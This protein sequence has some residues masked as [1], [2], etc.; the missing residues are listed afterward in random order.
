MPTLCPGARPDAIAPRSDNPFPSL[1]RAYA[2]CLGGFLTDANRFYLRITADGVVHG[3]IR[4]HQYGATFRGKKRKRR[5]EI[6]IAHMN[7]TATFVPTRSSST[8]DCDPQGAEYCCTFQVM[9]RLHH[10]DRHTLSCHVHVPVAPDVPAVGTWQQVSTSATIGKDSTFLKHLFQW[11]PLSRHQDDAARGL[12]SSLYPLRPGTYEFRGFTT[13]HRRSRPRTG[14]RVRP[15]ASVQDPCLVTLELLPD[16]TLRGTSREVVQPQ[17]CDLR[18]SWEEDRVTYALEYR[19][20][21]AVG[22]FRYSGAIRMKEEGESGKQRMVTRPDATGTS[23]RE[24]LSGKWYNVDRGHA[25]GY[26]GGRGDFE[27]EL[28]RTDFTPLSVRTDR[29]LVSLHPLQEQPPPRDAIF[30]FTSGDYELSGCATDAD[31]YEYAF[32][33]T[34]QLHPGGKLVGESKERIFRQ[35]SVVYGQWGP[36]QM[37]YMQHYVVHEEVGVYMYTADLI[38]DGAAVQGTWVNTEPEAAPASS[39]HGTFALIVVHATRRWSPCSHVHYPARF[40]AGV[41]TTLLTSAR[42]KT[43]PG[44][45]WMHVFAFCDETWFTPSR[46]H[47]VQ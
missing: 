38:H 22:H 8:I 15:L 6:V 16:G 18:G 10:V 29:E 20:R 25:E 46:K 13:N 33:L 23:Q 24:V 44:V 42:G 14:R 9:K 31:G 45:L 41:L 43:L 39:E 27:L 47:H 35:T 7:G 3:E 12:A 19:V 30:A 36:T 4:R 34:L 5:E 11:E 28:V 40:R 37:V 17:V 21:E 2:G 26:A 32:D 1:E